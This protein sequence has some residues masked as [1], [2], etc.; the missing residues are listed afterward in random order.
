MGF[1]CVRELKDL[2]PEILML[3]LPGHTHGHAG[4]AVRRPNGWLLQA[5]DA[6]F[7][8]A[9]MDLER[10]RCT[11]G[12]RL[13]QW[14]MEKDRAQRLL[15]QDRLRELKRAHGRELTLC[16]GH[17]PEEFEQL[18]TRPAGAPAQ[19][20]EPWANELRERHLANA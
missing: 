6:Y 16:C 20:R 12:L 11:P 15:N 8:H 3:P 17:D 2:P 13:Y 4:V 5:G 1:E 14:M 10:P 9:E 18:S 7:H 19:R